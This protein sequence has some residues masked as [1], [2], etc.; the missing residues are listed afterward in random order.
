M[1]G[2]Q[3]FFADEAT[4]QM[5][6][7][8]DAFEAVPLIAAMQQC[9]EIGRQ[10]MRDNFTSSATPDGSNWPPRKR[11]GDGHPLLIDRGPL[12]QAATGGGAGHVEQVEDREV[13]LG[14]DGSV[15]AYAATHNFGRGNVPQRE[16]AGLKPEREDACEAVI[17]DALMQE[18]FG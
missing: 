3:Q 17:A 6:L 10:S 5:S 11:Q 8:A 18:V 12:L 15:I 4:A 7:M 9:A 2:K 16:Y 14:V 13:A 1:I